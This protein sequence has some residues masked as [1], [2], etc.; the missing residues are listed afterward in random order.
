MRIRSVMWSAVMALGGR[1]RRLQPMGKRIFNIV[2][3]LVLVT[4]AALPAAGSSINT[5]PTWNGITTISSL[6]YPNTSSYGEVI[7]AP[8][9]SILTGFSFYLKEPVGFEFQAFVAHWDPVGDDNPGPISYGSPVVTSTTY[10]LIQYSVAGLGVPVTGGVPYL[11]YV[12]ID[13]V[14]ASDAGFTGDIGSMGGELGGTFGNAPADYFV[15]AN[16]G[17]NGAALHSNWNLIGCAN[18]FGDCGQAAFVADFSD[19]SSVPEPASLTLLTT[20][21]VGLIVRRRDKRGAVQCHL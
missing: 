21:L 6:G 1:G 20:G 5:F 11:L 12:T 9:T 15:Y 4:L 3:P 2:A 18:S 14:Y 7:T 17:G 16:D 19:P 10:S 13:G 8:S